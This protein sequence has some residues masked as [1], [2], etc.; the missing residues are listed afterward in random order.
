MLFFNYEEYKILVYTLSGLIF[1]LY[2][3]LYRRKHAWL[4][5]FGQRALIDR[6]SKIPNI[7]RNLLKGLSIS[8]AFC[9]MSLAILQP[10]WQTTQDYYEKE[11]LE[12]VFVLDVS[13][14]MLAED[15]KP[16]RL[17]RAKMEISNLVR[18][19]EDDRVGLVVFAARAFSLLPYPTNDY[20]KV[21]LR[22]LNMINENYVRFVP[23]GTNIGNA[24]ILA[25]NSFSKENAKKIM[26]FLTDG[27]EQ[28][29][30]RSQIAEAVKLLL[31]KKDIAIYVVGIG[32]S[33]KA[34]PIPKRDKEGNVIG[35]EATE[36]GETI[37]TKPNPKF[38][39][40]IAEIV[41]GTY[42]H[43]ATGDELK[44]IFTQ[45]IEQNKNIIGIKKKNIIRDVSQYFLGGALALLALY[46]IL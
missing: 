13:I 40:E 36:E 31:E 19:L 11:G 8:A 33:K 2:L 43:D 29:I 23:Y 25:M 20:E 4:K 24:F 10:K 18:E 3:F 17:Q 30:T 44:H 34:S 42:Q 26:I 14:S 5:A 39:G 15:V 35:Y 1:L 37:Y 6:F 9:A 45:V 32:D 38:L 12:I 27:E 46:F 22:I 16:N 41:G 21:F 28:I 7:Y